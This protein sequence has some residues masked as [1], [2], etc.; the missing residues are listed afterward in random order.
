MPEKSNG[1]LSIERCVPFVCRKC[2]RTLGM[3]TDRELVNGKFRSTQ[4]M[5][6]LCQCGAYRQWRPLMV[7]KSGNNSLQV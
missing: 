5:V 2:G 6:V 3:T 4:R 1:H 7:R